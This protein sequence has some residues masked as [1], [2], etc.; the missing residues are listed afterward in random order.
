M[1]DLE[2]NLSPIGEEVESTI[3]GSQPIAE[4]TIE[5]VHAPILEVAK[6]TKDT[7]NDFI[8]FKFFLNRAKG[9]IQVLQ[10]KILTAQGVELFNA[11]GCGVIED[12][13]GKYFAITR[14]DKSIL[15]EFGRSSDWTFFENDDII[16][17]TRRNGGIL[18][19]TLKKC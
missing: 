14:P 15:I 6:P 11:K 18:E 5:E 9:R 3:D 17:A 7:V 13:Q 16:R 2:I 4:D 8:S 1:K 19:L 12:V 10:H